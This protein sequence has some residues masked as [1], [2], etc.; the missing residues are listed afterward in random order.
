L[1]QF[2]GHVFLLVRRAIEFPQIIGEEKDFQDGEHYKQLDEYNQPKRFANGHTPESVPVKAENAYRY[3]LS[4]H[5]Q[6]Y[7][8]FGKKELL[9][10]ARA[11]FMH[12]PRGQC[13]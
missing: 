4:C 12:S 8:F 13:H 10:R 11:I 7:S 1:Y 2:V 5:I 3:G 9:Y 6:I